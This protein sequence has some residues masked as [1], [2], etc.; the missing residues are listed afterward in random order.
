MAPDL[1][2]ED[3]PIQPVFDEKYFFYNWNDNNPP[4]EIPPPIMDDIDNDWIISSVEKKEEFIN[5]H[6]TQIYE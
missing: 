2:G 5:E 6:V 4:I 3:P 1:G